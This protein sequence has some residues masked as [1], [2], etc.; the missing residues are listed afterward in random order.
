M[1]GKFQPL[2]IALALAAAACSPVAAPGQGGQTLSATIV[3]R[4]DAFTV[5]ADAGP[6]KD[7]QP[8]G[9][10]TLRGDS[11]TVI[12]PGGGNARV[13]SPGSLADLP[14]AP[15]TAVRVTIQVP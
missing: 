2:V 8:G 10:V 1:R 9:I 11:K 15:G 14:L 12:Q 3:E 7:A 5:R 13:Q 4:V 6:G